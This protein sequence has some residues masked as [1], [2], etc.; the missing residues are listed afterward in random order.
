MHHFDNEKVAEA[1]ARIECHYFT[2]RGFFD[3]DTWILDNVSKIKH[4]P[5]I[6]IQGR[7]DVVC[8]MRSA[9]DLHQKWK[10]SNLIIV[11]DSGH[12]ML[13]KGIQEKLI[14]YTEKFIKY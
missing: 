11:P 4:I 5:N 3:S 1:F 14:D 13:E 9:W 2:N 8:P 6:I 7:Y 12:S 10:K